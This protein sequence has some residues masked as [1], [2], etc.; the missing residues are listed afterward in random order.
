M[1]YD[2]CILEQ[3]IRKQRKVLAALIDNDSPD[4]SKMIAQERKKLDSLYKERRDILHISNDHKVH[5]IHLQQRRS[6]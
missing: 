5:I 2:F 4:F 3:E 1:D 6:R